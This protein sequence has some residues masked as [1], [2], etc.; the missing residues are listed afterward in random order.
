MLE[1]VGKETVDM[2]ITEAGLEVGK[3]NM[4]FDHQTDVEQFEEITFERC[5]YIYGGPDQLQV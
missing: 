1:R 4:G 3:S 5:F 2:L